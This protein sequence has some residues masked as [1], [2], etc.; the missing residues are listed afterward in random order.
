MRLESSVLALI[1]LR[2]L[3]DR[4]ILILS[5]SASLFSLPPLIHINRNRSMDQKSRPYVER[6]LPLQLPVRKTAKQSCRTTSHPVVLITTPP[7]LVSR[8]E[9]LSI[10]SSRTTHPITI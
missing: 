3:A 5:P 9:L 8:Y 4:P 2:L 6:L 1:S 7:H 10:V